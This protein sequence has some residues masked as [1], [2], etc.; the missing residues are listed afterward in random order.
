MMIMTDEKRGGDGERCSIFKLKMNNKNNK[1]KNKK[2][3]EFYI[4]S[5]II[6]VKIIMIVIHTLCIAVSSPLHS[7]NQDRHPDVSFLSPIY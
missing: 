3:H 4:V 1:N 6:T 2:L 5:I 7:F